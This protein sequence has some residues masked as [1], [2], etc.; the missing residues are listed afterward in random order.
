MAQ[1]RSRDSVL[2]AEKK[3]SPGS[4][5]TSSQSHRCRLVDGCRSMRRWTRIKRY[6]A[7]DFKEIVWPSPMEDPPGT[8]AEVRRKLTLRENLE[9]IRDG[10]KD[11]L[12]GWKVSL[13]MDKKKG[14]ETDQAENRTDRS[15]EEW[16]EDAEVAAKLGA[17]RTA[18]GIKPILQR[19][20]F[21]RLSIYKE[22]VQNFVEGYR[23]G[24]REELQPEKEGKTD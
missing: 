7:H 15:K 16:H 24:L 10:T 17:I 2:L 21:T 9:C 11:Y 19:L 23:E 22:A 18:E 5:P 20:Y 14:E 13:G 3:L 4:P 1:P 6:F 12:E 8:V